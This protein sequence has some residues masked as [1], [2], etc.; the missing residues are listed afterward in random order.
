M[1]GRGDRSVLG[2]PRK[3]KNSIG[4]F[5]V[6]VIALLVATFV[7]T[8]I[9]V[10]YAAKVSPKVKPNPLNF[11]S[12]YLALSTSSVTETVTVSNPHKGAAIT[13]KNINPT[14]P[15]F[16]IT[17]GT[18]KITGALSPGNS[19]TILVTFTPI[20]V[21][22]RQATL[23]VE[24]GAVK[25]KV[26]LS[27]VALSPSLTISP[28]NLNFGSQPMGTTSPVLQTVTVTNNSPVI[29][30]ISATLVQGS[31]N[32]TGCVGALNPGA[33]CT[34]TVSTM[35]ICP[36]N[37][38]GTLRIADD[39]IDSP[40][41]IALSVTGI[42]GTS[43]PSEAVLLAGGLTKTAHGVAPTNTAEIFN[44]ST[45]SDTSAGSMTHPRAFQTQT[46]LDPA[47]VSSE[48][49]EVL[50]TGGQ[51]DS[52]GTI[53]NT[54]EL[55]DP[56][57]G[58]F[59][60]TSVPMTDP[61]MQH[62][63]TLLRE[64][65][66]AGMVLIVGG[67]PTGAVADGTSEL[68]DPSSNSFTPSGPL[69]DPRAAHAAAAIIGC[70]PACPQEGDVIVAGG[71]DSGGQANNTAEVFDPAT[72]TFSCVRGIDSSTGHCESSLSSA[73]DDA[74]A[75]LLPSG[76]VAFIGGNSANAGKFPGTPVRGIDVYL[77]SVATMTTGPTMSEG[78]D[79]AAIALIPMGPLAGDVLATGGA[80]LTGASTDTAE[81]YSPAHNVFTCVQGLS[82]LAPICNPSMASSRASHIAVSF[83]A[84]PMS[85]MAL[86]AGGINLGTE[87]ILNSTEVFNSITATF[88]SVSSMKTPRSDFTAT[89]I[90]LP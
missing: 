5:H 66:L 61:R 33:Q 58:E 60:P 71:H 80:D 2:N 20:Q 85:D 40:Q 6:L 3:N 49:G 54:A 15:D 29:I 78:R 22:H 43:G 69:T 32:A 59:T 50:I 90:P 52:K 35:P 68:Y 88:Q 83:D 23:Y 57:T 51:I 73:R 53:T 30:G 13:F 89:V 19:C 64:G 70:G 26:H 8:N 11:P 1:W 77:P 27:G 9:G 12:Q 37:S 81:I 67:V 21:G 56:S 74:A 72:R 86:I 82:A 42:A 31:Y 87:T 47:I 39:A 76:N 24:W 16:V 45:C 25:V 28:T 84:G 4:A 79:L 10:V 34:L 55:F 63:A 46:Y 7:L 44:S 38:T 65:P 75:E 36:G 41:P 18:C 62:T 48:G 17:G 14:Q